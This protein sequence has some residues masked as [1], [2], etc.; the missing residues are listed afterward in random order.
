M[1]KLQT[2]L[3]YTSKCTSSLKGRCGKKG[4]RGLFL[5][6][7][8]SNGTWNQVKY[9]GCVLTD[10]LPLPFFSQHFIKEM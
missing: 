8:F 5:V 1:P 2:Y 3:R 10:Q 6:K 4:V 7:I 9:R